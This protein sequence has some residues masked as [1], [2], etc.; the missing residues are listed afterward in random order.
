MS[1]KGP[2]NVDFNRKY[3]GSYGMGGLGLKLDSTEINKK[4][5]RASL[6][7]KIVQGI[8][9]TFFAKQYWKVRRVGKREIIQVTKQKIKKK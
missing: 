5:P 3:S 2:A 4:I 9:F 6:V 7:W 1:Q 8:L